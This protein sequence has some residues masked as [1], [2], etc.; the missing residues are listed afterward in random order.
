MKRYFLSWHK[1]FEDGICDNAYETLA[2]AQA[3]Q[4]IH[5]VTAYLYEVVF[6]D[7]TVKLMEY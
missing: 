2:A 1:D 7:P 3:G 6:S 5:E 4:Y